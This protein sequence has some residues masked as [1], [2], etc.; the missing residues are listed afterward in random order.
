MLKNKYAT[1]ESHQKDVEKLENELQTQNK[2]YNKL[3][4]ESESFKSK[5]IDLEKDL[6]Y[7]KKKKEDHT[8]KIHSEIERGMY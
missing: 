7:E 1:T 6:A 2:L 5:I 4:K 8:K 3:I